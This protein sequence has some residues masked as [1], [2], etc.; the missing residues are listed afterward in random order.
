MVQAGVAGFK[1]FLIHSGVDEFPHV[2]DA[3]LHAAMKQLQGTDS[4]LLVSHIILFCL[5]NHFNLISDLMTHFCHDELLIN[6]LE[7][8]C[9][10]NL[11][12]AININHEKSIMLLMELKM[13][14]VLQ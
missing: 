8:N 14:E 5:P 13:N 12:A 9:S 1:C 4:V 6:I 3:D 11:Y 10:D 2:S 7:H